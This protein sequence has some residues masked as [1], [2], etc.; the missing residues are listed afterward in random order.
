MVNMSDRKPLTISPELH[1]RVKRLA[2]DT[3]VSLKDVSAMLLEYSLERHSAGE[4]AIG[5]ASVVQSPSPDANADLRHRQSKTPVKA[6]DLIPG[7]GNRK[8]KAA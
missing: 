5:R 2:V 4:I 3:G 6:K 1:R 8:G 7:R